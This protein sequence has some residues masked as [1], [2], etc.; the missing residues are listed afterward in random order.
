MRKAVYAWDTGG[1][2]WESTPMLDELYVY[3]GWNV[4]LVVNRNA[5]NAVTRRYTWGL[6]LSGLAGQEPRPRSRGLSRAVRRT[7]RPPRTEPRL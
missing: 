7:V 6:D 1:S 5:S 2:Q 3:D 4:V